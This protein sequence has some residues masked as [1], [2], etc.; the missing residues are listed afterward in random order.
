MPTL[1]PLSNLGVSISQEGGEL[2]VYSASATSM[3]LCLHSERDLDWVSEAI[4]MD[5]DEHSVWSISSPKLA[6]GVRYSLRA[7]GPSDGGVSGRF[8]PKLLLI[9][10]YSRGL[11][12]S[13]SGAWR[14]CV[15]DEPFDWA[16]TVKPGI[17]I[18]RTIIYEAHAKGLTKLNPALPEEL[19]GSYAGLA[20][21][22][23]IQYLVDLGITAVE[24]LPVH[25]FITEQRLLKMGLTN[26]W[27]YNT[28][29]FFTPHAAWASPSAQKAGPG[30]ILREFK[31]M[32]K[33]LH[34]AGL[35]V[36]LDVVFNHT[37]EE[38]P[39]GPT[40]S[41]RGLDDRTYYRQDAAGNYIDTT[42]C[43]N[44][45][46]PNSAASQRLILDSLRYW[47]SEVQID[48]FRF[49]LAVT[50]GR[51]EAGDFDPEHPLLQAITDDPLLSGC[52]LIAEPWDVGPNG[53][54]TGGFPDGW[55]E[56]ND[57]YRDRIRSFWLTDIATARSSG[58]A[59]IGI[60]K[61]AT[62]ISGSSDVYS[63]ERGP[64]ASVNFVTAHDGFT[65]WDLTTFNQKHNLGNGE[66]NRDGTD[67]NHSFNHGVEGETDDS[68][69]TDQRRRAI[70]NLL[71]SL[72]LSAGTP[73]ITAGD[74]I[75]RSQRGNN[76]A[77][78]HDDELSWL[79]W[80]LE[81]WQRELREIVKAATRFRVENPAVRP[82]DFGVHGESVETASQ[83]EWFD[84]GGSTMSIDD[85]NS[86]EARTLQFLASSTHAT[87]GFNRILL[88]F[89]GLETE[90][91]LTLPFHSGV[92]NYRL[93][94]DSAF[95][96]IKQ[97]NHAP[98][99][100]VTMSGT[101]MRL[102]WAD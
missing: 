7:V 57:R 19:R 33:L 8:D 54:H 71:A 18:D 90:V 47:A 93:L 40:S 73:M 30:A 32:V 68:Q 79:P 38:G 26:Y 56:W 101:S 59:P 27:G 41:L 22:S 91:E 49:D 55:L 43:G 36:F 24:L 100:V 61:L 4:P 14:S 94:F 15:V 12:R 83:M 87:D 67:T 29:S 17:P 78:C 58:S 46:N 64:I 51:N 20:H 9:D 16:G 80:E 3:Q 70:R 84:A 28:L 44:S 82:R 86:P 65:A 98:G 50:L 1:D 74:E 92:S 62:R 23:T 6:N 96:W 102:Y 63:A 35:E 37:S 21:E 77:Y 39:G 5:R 95:D 69:V 34:E 97:S 13:G 89:H 10:P 81:D 66:D 88:A 31:G 99:S 76:N 11:V 25:Q 45:I 72:L 48:G 2:R 42:G 60:G 53:W 75:A 52:K 85:W